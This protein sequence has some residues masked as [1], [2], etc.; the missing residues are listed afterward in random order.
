MSMMSKK[1]G[2]EPSKDASA[3]QVSEQQKATAAVEGLMKK[4]WSGRVE[5]KAPGMS[6][7]AKLPLFRYTKPQ[8]HEPE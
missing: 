7:S 8:S 6:G 1:V 5:D 4:E 2:P 3:L